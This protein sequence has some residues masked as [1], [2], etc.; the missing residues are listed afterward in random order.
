MS[1]NLHVLLSVH[2]QPV[3]VRLVTRAKCNFGSR[4]PN[5][6]QAR[7]KSA[8][9]R[10]REPRENPTHPHPKFSLTRGRRGLFHEAHRAGSEGFRNPE[11][12]SPHTHTHVDSS[13]C[14]VWRRGR[15]ISLSSF[16]PYPKITKDNKPHLMGIVMAGWAGRTHKTNCLREQELCS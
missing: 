15:P 1:C 4:E 7:V 14:E 5:C 10:L 3:S 9:R 13:E 8:H 16:T 6:A 2:L 12:Q 11:P